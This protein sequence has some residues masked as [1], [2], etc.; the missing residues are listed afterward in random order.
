M[1]PNDKRS[2]AR[3][4]RRF[5]IWKRRGARSFAHSPGDRSDIVI[6]PRLLI[7]EPRA[8]SLSRKAE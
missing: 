8:V 3:P 6:F 7:A 1:P 4:A 2:D 5:R